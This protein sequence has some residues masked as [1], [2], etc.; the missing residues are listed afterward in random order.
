MGVTLALDLID[1]AINAHG[2]KLEVTTI[3][4]FR[5]KVTLIS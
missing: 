2:G 3:D 1:Q 4:S 5:K